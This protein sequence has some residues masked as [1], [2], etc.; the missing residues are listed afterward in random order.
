M[1]TSVKLNKGGK[2]NKICTKSAATNDSCTSN[3]VI[4]C[5]LVQ[6]TVRQP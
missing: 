3:T 1:A 6:G 5:Q 2:K 4:T